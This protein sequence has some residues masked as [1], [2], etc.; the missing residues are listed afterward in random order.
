MFDI[1]IWIS[2]IFTELHGPH[3]CVNDAHGFS[4]AFHRVA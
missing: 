4:S 2:S 3:E 1:Y